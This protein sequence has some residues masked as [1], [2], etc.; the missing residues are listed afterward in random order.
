MQP[1]INHMET[2]WQP[3]GNQDNFSQRIIYIFNE[4]SKMY[5]R[6]KYQLSRTKS[7]L[8]FNMNQGSN[9]LHNH[10]TIYL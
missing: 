6:N 3:V 1:K 4:I 5:I 2:M 7:K 9:L 8:T 10:Y